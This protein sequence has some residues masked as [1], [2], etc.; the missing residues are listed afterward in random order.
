MHIGGIWFAKGLSKMFLT[1]KE[2]LGNS[3]DKKGYCR[4]RVDRKLGIPSAHI[5]SVNNN[6][7]ANVSNRGPLNVRNRIT[8]SPCL[9]TRGSADRHGS[10]ISGGSI[11]SPTDDRPAQR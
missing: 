2:Y 9:A 10:F 3:K 11:P 1:L 7:H 5:S 6:P 8:Q 4:R